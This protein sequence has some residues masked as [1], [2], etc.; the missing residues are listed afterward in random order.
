MVSRPKKPA[1]RAG[2]P[3]AFDHI[4]PGGEC[5]PNH[6]ATQRGNPAPNRRSCEPRNLQW[7]CDNRASTVPASPEPTRFKMSVPANV[8]ARDDTPI[9][10]DALSLLNSVFGLTAFRGAQ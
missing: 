2:V 3:D 7:T 9:A 6:G 5:D 10:R 1:D 4:I 8:P